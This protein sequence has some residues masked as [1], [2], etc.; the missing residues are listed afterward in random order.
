MTDR[1]DPRTPPASIL[2]A[3]G[4]EMGTLMREHPW[5]ATALGPVEQWPQSLT[6]AVRILLTSR[7]AMWM[8]WGP[9]LSFFYNDAYRR[10]TLGKKHPWALGRP[11][12]EV[13]GEIWDDISPRIQ[14]VLD[15]GEATWDEGLL[16]FLERSGYPE[17]TYHTFSYSPLTDDAGRSSGMFCVVMEETERVIGE[18]RLATLR[19][20]AAELAAAG[21]EDA[22]LAAVERGVSGSRKDL[23]FTLTYLF[24]DGHTRARLAACTGFRAGD[25]GAPETIEAGAAAQAW[26]AGELLAGCARLVIDPLPASL[27]ELPT[28][29]WDVPPRAAIA[30]PI[31]RPGQERPAGFLVAGLNPFRPFDEAYE[32]FVGLVAGQIAASL[33]NARV[34]EEER[35][36]AQALAEL[37]QAKTIFFSNI[38]HE[39][40]TP[41][42]LILGPA[43]EGRADPA[44]TED[45]RARWD[46]VQ[47]NGRRLQKLVNTLLEFSRIEAGRVQAAYEPVDLAAFTRDLASLFRSALERAG[48]RL[49]IDAPALPEPVYVDRDMWEK[50]VLNLLSN[51]FKHTFS[52]TVTVALHAAGDAV[53]L[54]VR[55]TGTGIPAEEIPLLFDRFHRVK[56]AASRTHEGT[57]IGLA[58]VRELVALHGG[59]IEV[60]STVGEGSTFTVRVPAGS[61]HLPAGQIGAPRVVESA[62]GGAF[63]QEALTWIPEAPAAP[64]DGPGTA[65][66]PEGILDADM[67]APAGERRADTILIADDNADMRAYLARLLGRQWHVDTVPDGV[68]ALA[69]VQARLPDLV[70]SDVMM[71]GLNGFELL[72]ALR[73][74]PR[75]RELPVL[76][77]SARAGEESRIEGMQAGADDYLAKPFSARELVARVGAHLELARVRRDAAARLRAAAEENAELYREA[78]EAKERLQEQAVE[79]ELQ[80]EELQTQTAHLEETQVDLESANNELR[81]VNAALRET[82]GRFRNMADNAPVMMWVTDPDGVCTH[83]NRQWYDFTGQTP[84]TGLGFGWLNATHP[85]DRPFAEQTFITSNATRAPFRVEYRLRRADGE[86]RWAIDAAVPRFDAGGA[87]LGYIGSVIDI[88]ERKEVEQQREIVLAESEQARRLADEANRAKSEFLA[89]MSHELRT[90]LNAIAGY[91]DLLD[92]EIHGPVNA[93]QH[94]AFDRIKRNQEVLLSL[95]N[96]VLNFA[97]LEAGRLEIECAEVDV[98]EVLNQVEPLIA[99]QMAAKR[100]AYAC[101]QCE[102]GLTALGDPERIQQVLINLLTNALKFTPSGGRVTVSAAPD[103]ARVHIR[104]TDTGRGIPAEKLE[105]IFDPFVQVDRRGSLAEESQLGVGLGLAISRELARAM[106]GELTVRSE[107]G[108]GSTFTLALPRAMDGAGAG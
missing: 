26:P 63:V 72:Q 73:A 86:Y 32:G 96:D 84:E 71:P 88:T 68:A 66:V 46:T 8:G 22:V 40:R 62:T 59:T 81:Q 27:G 49:E 101:E 64:A 83:L 92:L 6:T 57:G 20:L 78:L 61:R 103:G 31:A 47:R 36:R 75:T 56:G 80:T 19:D 16:L 76:L 44:L 77:L 17:E 107:P 51:A 1:M 45:E 53:E 54:R 14:S 25:P 41:L 42:T 48:L 33:A 35:R 12:R 67:P 79:L 99:P 94:H 50:I 24:E 29:A 91:L 9:D 30:V 100:L 2:L 38:S 95:I 85:D 108:A 18:R 5:A 37:D 43:E 21:R 23:P 39:F 74:N 7:F 97:K 90:P 4:G 82:E 34:F 104:V 52:G 11:T 13:W 65:G 102:P 10:D 3:G 28:G 58:L 105:S 60:E 70:L 15:T 93:A 55:D 87:Y 106:D 98:C 69:A 89:N